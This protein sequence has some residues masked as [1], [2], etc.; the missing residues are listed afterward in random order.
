[1]KG[2]PRVLSYRERPC[3]S[4]TV[5]PRCSQTVTMGEESEE[6]ERGRGEEEEGIA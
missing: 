6:G 2:F 3:T 5:R 4:L 1:M